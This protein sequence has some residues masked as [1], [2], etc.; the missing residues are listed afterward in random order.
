LEIPSFKTQKVPQQESKTISTLISGSKV[1]HYPHYISLM[2]V[3]G[4]SVPISG[5]IYA[6][7]PSGFGC[8]LLVNKLA[9]EIWLKLDF[10]HKIKMFTNLIGGKEKKKTPPNCMNNIHMQS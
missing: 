9:H 5:K 7:V 1:T 6:Y 3:L 8:E 4:R 2:Q 10:P